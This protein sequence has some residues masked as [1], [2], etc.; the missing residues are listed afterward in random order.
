MKDIIIFGRL[1]FV[2]IEKWMKIVYDYIIMKNPVPQ[3]KS[4]IVSFFVIFLISVP[5]FPRIYPQFGFNSYFGPKK[6]VSTAPWFGIRLPVTGYSSLI[7]KVNYQKISYR[8]INFDEEEMTIKKTMTHLV[9]VYY[10]QKNRVDFYTAPSL[11]LGNDNYYGVALDLGGSYRLF[12]R[13]KI[14]GGVYFLREKSSLWYPDE[15]IRGIN[16]Y[17]ANFGFSY[18]IRGNL[19]IN[20]KVF[21]SKN[22]EEIR[23]TAYSVGVG[24][25]LKEQIYLTIHYSRYSESLQYRYSGNYLTAGLN[26]Y[27]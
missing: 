17:S 10:Y 2:D 6:L 15:E 24:C 3:K 8:Y 13:L 1:F 18:F 23:A 4:M 16:L 7:F 25:I 11:L 22:S 19:F 12:S 26:I 9:S 14:E 20:P 5:L 21:L 27:L